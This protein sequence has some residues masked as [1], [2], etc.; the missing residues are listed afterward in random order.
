MAKELYKITIIDEDKE[1][2]TVY[3]TNISQA[4]FLGFIEISGIEFPNQSDIILTPGE[5]KAQSLF[6]DTKIIIIPGNYIIRIEELKED[7]KA[8]IINIY[9][10]VK[11]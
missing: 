9:N 10:P 2:T 11:N 8:L 5:D 1:H 3:A 6:K 4:D 7:K